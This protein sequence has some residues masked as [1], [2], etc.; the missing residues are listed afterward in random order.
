MA[1]CGNCKQQT[2]RIRQDYDER[3]RFLREYCV[4]CKPEKFSDQPVTDPSDKK[5]YVGPDALPHMY[6]QGTAGVLRAK[7]ELLTDTLSILQADPDKEARDRAI[8]KKRKNRR[9][10]P[11][12]RAEIA[13]AERWGREVLKPR[14]DETF[15]N[16]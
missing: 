11:M 8:A 10:T 4:L 1:L 16:V 14:M 2:L 3:N 6:Y 7:D 15:P 12:S 13:A 9:T 5:I